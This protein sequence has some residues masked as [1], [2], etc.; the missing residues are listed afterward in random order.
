MHNEFKQQ[1]V[2]SLKRWKLFAVSQKLIIIS[3][4]KS[5]D[6]ISP[7]AQ[8]V[9]IVFSFVFVFVF[10]RLQ[11]KNYDKKI[12]TY[13]ELLCSFA[14]SLCCPHLKVTA[15]RSSIWNE[16]E[17]AIRVWNF[18]QEKKCSFIWLYWILCDG[19]PKFHRRNGEN[20]QN[21]N[22]CAVTI[23]IVGRVASC[24]DIEAIE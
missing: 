12:L 3:S 7:N 21:I 1:I 2:I 5:V 14:N 10:S 6:C 16:T 23:S 20:F 19:V 4:K 13:S 22:W 24:N 8:Q 18:C 17:K 11:P 9:I 15:C